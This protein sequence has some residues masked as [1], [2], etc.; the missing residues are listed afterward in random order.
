MSTNGAPAV[1]AADYL[2]ALKLAVEATADQHAEIAVVRQILEAAPDPDI[3]SLWPTRILVDAIR[4]LEGT[5]S[6]P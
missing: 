1:T 6:V 4:A 2:G 5:V 3:H